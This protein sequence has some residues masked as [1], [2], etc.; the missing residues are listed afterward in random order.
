MPDER[1]K[2]QGQQGDMGHGQQRGS[3]TPGRNPQDEQSAREKSGGHD[4]KGSQFESDVERNR[5]DPGFKEGGQ[6]EETRR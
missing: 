4:R 5:Q 2:N 1:N 6:N 3:Q